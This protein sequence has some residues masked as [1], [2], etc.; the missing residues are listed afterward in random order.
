MDKINK[1]QRLYFD[2]I[3]HMSYDQR[4]TKLKGIC[5]ILTFEI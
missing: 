4:K 5:E 1:E 2:E 3:P